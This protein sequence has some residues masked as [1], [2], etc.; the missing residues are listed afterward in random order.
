M[1]LYERITCA[2]M[3]ITKRRNFPL[4]FRHP[5]PVVTGSAFT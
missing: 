5:L 4:W 1:T 3:A 2:V